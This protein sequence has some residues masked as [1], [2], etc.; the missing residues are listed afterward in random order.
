MLHTY[1]QPV[2]DSRLGD[3]FDTYIYNTVKLP[4]RQKSR[5]YDFVLDCSDDLTIFYLSVVD[6][7]GMQR[8]PRIELDKTG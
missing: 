7:K 4:Q 2:Q 3:Q 5:L 8:E 6:R 1:I